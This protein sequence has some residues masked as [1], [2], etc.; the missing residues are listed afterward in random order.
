MIKFKDRGEFFDTLRHFFKIGELVTRKLDL[1]DYSFDTI[2]YDDENTGYI[3]EMSDGSYSYKILMPSKFWDMS[4]SEIEKVLK[5]I[6]KDKFEMKY[7][8]FDLKN[9][10]S[11]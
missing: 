4:I 8:F 7:S 10:V 3:L 5:D 1:P 9:I 11:L 2:Y 6:P